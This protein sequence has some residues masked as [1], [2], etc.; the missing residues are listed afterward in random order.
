MLETIA[1]KAPAIVFYIAAA[2]AAGIGV[3]FFWLPMLSLPL[4][5]VSFTAFTIAGIAR[6]K[7]REI[8]VRRQQGG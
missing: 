3:L 7:A 8:E 6:R 1:A 2:I 4:I 5:A